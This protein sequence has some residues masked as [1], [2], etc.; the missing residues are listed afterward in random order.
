MTQPWHGGRGGSR[1]KGNSLWSGRGFGRQ[2]ARANVWTPSSSPRAS[3]MVPSAAPTAGS[4]QSAA[5]K[6]RT[7]VRKAADL[8]EAASE[9]SAAEIEAHLKE[10]QDRLV[11]VVAQEEEVRVIVKEHLER[12]EFLIKLL[13]DLKRKQKEEQEGTSLPAGPALLLASAAAPPV[14]AIQSAGAGGTAGAAAGAA[15]GEAA[16]VVVA[17]AD[18]TVQDAASQAA[19]Q[20]DPASSPPKLAINAAAAAAAA[21]VATAGSSP[22]SAQAGSSSAGLPR[23]RQQQA[24]AGGS[25]RDG[26]AGGSAVAAAAATAGGKKTRPS[27]LLA[28]AMGTG[29]TPGGD[30]FLTRDTDTIAEYIALM[31]H[32]VVA[33]EAQTAAV[34]TAAE[35]GRPVAT[36]ERWRQTGLSLTEALDRAEA[37]AAYPARMPHL[38]ALAAAIRPLN[39]AYVA[40]G[41]ASVD[42]SPFSSGASK[43]KANDNGSAVLPLPV[44][45]A[46]A[47]GKARQ[48]EG[49]SLKRRRVD[50][51]AIMCPFELNGVCNDDDCR[52]QHLDVYLPPAAPVA[53]LTPNETS[54]S[55]F[56]S[57][58]APDA[59]GN[60]STGSTAAGS[61]A[62]V[63]KTTALREAALESKQWQ[64]PAID[65]RG[66][67]EGRQ[68]RQAA[69]GGGDRSGGRGGAEPPRSSSSPDK[70][71]VA[72]SPATDEPK[73]GTVGGGGG[74]GGDPEENEGGESGEE[75]TSIDG[76]ED[77]LPLPIEIMQ[78]ESGGGGGGGGGGGTA[79]AEADPSSEVAAAAVAASSPPAPAERA[80]PAAMA[81]A[82]ARAASG[83]SAN[84]GRGGG[85]GGAKEAGGIRSGQE[86][87]YY[88][89]EGGDGKN[90]RAAAAALTEDQLSALEAQLN[91][92][93]SCDVEGWLLLALHRLP[94]SGDSAMA[95]LNTVGG[96]ARGVGG[97]MGSADRAAIKA[98]LRTF[99]QPLERAEGGQAEALWLLY[100]RLFAFLPGKSE[101]ALGMAE[102]ALE[103][104]PASRRLWRL[105]HSMLKK[106]A[107]WSLA[108]ELSCYQRQLEALVLL[109]SRVAPA[110]QASSPSHRSSCNSSSSDIREEK[111]KTGKTERSDSGDGGAS[112]GGSSGGAGGGAGEG[113]GGGGGGKDAIDEMIVYLV[114]ERCSLLAESGY[115]LQAAAET[116]HALGALTVGHPLR[117]WDDADKLG[118]RT[119]LR[120]PSD[121]DGGASSGAGVEA[122]AGA[123]S[124]A[125]TS[126]DGQDFPKGVAEALKHAP[127]G[128]RCV[129]WLTA[130][131]LLVMSVFPRH[132]L[133]VAENGVGGGGDDGLA[134]GSTHGNDETRDL[135]HL[136]LW[137]KE[138]LSLPESSNGLE[139]LP[140]NAKLLQ[141]T[142]LKT[143]MSALHDVGLLPREGA[144][145]WAPPTRARDALLSSASEAKAARTRGKAPEPSALEGARLVLALNWLAFCRRRAD[146]NQGRIMA[147]ACCR[148]FQLA[149]PDHPALLEHFLLEHP[150]S[151]ARTL[152]DIYD[153]ISRAFDSAGVAAEALRERDGQD[154]EEKQ[155]PPPPAVSAAAAGG[156]SSS[157]SSS[158]GENACLSVSSSSP[159]LP[160]SGARVQAVYPYLRFVEMRLETSAEST[161]KP[162][163][164]SAAAAAATGGDTL[165]SVRCVL[166]KSLVGM[167]TATAASA[168]SSPRSEVDRWLRDEEGDELVRRALEGAKASLFRWADGGSDTGPA[169]LCAR[170]PGSRWSDGRRR[171]RC[172][173]FSGRNG[174]R[175]L[176]TIIFSLWVLGGASAAIGA[177]DHLL[178]AESFSSMSA[179]RRRIAW[180]QRLEAAVV[181][182]KQQ[183]QVRGEDPMQGA[184]EVAL[185]A[186]ADPRTYRR[187]EYPTLAHFV[188]ATLDRPVAGDK[189]FIGDSGNKPGKS[190]SPSS[191]LAAETSVASSFAFDVLTVYAN[192]FRKVR[193][194]VDWVVAAEALARSGG[195][196]DGGGAGAPTA[197]AA[198]ALLRWVSWADNGEGGVAA[199]TAAAGA[200]VADGTFVLKSFAL[201]YAERALA[202]HP[203]DPGLSGAVAAL[204]AA[205]GC[206]GRAQ[207]FLEAA[208][209]A[210]PYCAVL[211]EQ[212]IALEAGF[213]SGSTERVGVTAS[214]A[215]T[216][217]ALMRL[218][219]GGNLGGKCPT[220]LQARTAGRIFTTV[221]HPSVRRETKSFSLQG[222]L[223]AT[224]DAGRGSSTPMPEVPRSVFLMT[225]LVYLSLSFNGLISV[226]VAVGR[227]PALRSLDVS[228]NVLSALP[229]SLSRLSGTLRVLRAAGNRLRSPLSAAP[230]G[231][232]VG[233]RVLDLEYNELSRFPEAVVLRLT[234]LRTLK[235]VGNAFSERPPAGLSDVL[236]HLGELTL[237]AAA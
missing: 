134:D 46:A 113:G 12:E 77:F 151:N 157:S 39:G 194:G 234:E 159:P 140:L 10:V 150:V 34:A 138:G 130:L 225:S 85:S 69:P 142:T 48:P 78:R 217:G 171:R 147:I 99:V 235:L 18:P 125:T 16:A 224:R 211:W 65:F 114:L 141:D 4:P 5:L 163:K 6:A 199:P 237:P 219:C 177:L 76:E 25:P 124:G 20:P 60:G 45:A 174:E 149:R 191:T 122:G 13:E 43:R 15:A 145:G 84:G 189:N 198:L 9:Q 27:L 143:F 40:A 148:R 229:L 221:S 94:R 206:P 1:G 162:P 41:R 203:G 75:T 218:S 112:G 109:R 230:L 164:K 185:R 66:E 166:H 127:P 160:P 89:L 207:R 215:A 37:T 172:C 72:V 54:P 79:S 190:I 8:V 95:V 47:D 58:S 158:R 55:T 153:E 105:Y 82:F 119:V 214:A 205:T 183:V 92:G 184:R 90:Q 180:L 131:H 168:V 226:P 93:A 118:R 61:A 232:L 32:D 17:A 195:G 97:P 64:L 50:A 154:N 178:S 49:R 63:A 29:V 33:E 152:E 7:S 169:E 116:L 30:D 133:A 88:H 57:A 74:G 98:A 132:A 52:Y 188:A 222:V 44:A 182:S 200:A 26:S 59:S 179:E 81:E 146:A 212:R 36:A 70:G 155:A 115:K 42:A 176:S 96:V 83:A 187:A 236:P 19:R 126:G 233:L 220:S 101:D 3:E 23:L 170:N 111:Y 80:S 144:Q 181:L 210:H 110:G 71:V 204:G 24:S 11:V 2:D 68:Q 102:Y 28:M 227:L 106:S 87:R 103:K 128:S 31:S 137:P 175:Q 213:G 139:G 228:G 121:G 161:S 91:E 197:G 129:L 123:S 192:H 167:W 14:E 201:Q 196:G 62:A 117:G 223:L 209:R 202:R 216:S 86:E 21:L 35:R 156:I 107:R 104:F 67:R 73:G 53:A 193:G 120:V 22:R 38:L 165:D 136:L 173:D 231:D 208:L 51:N 56:A 100:L 108:G 186:L 135:A